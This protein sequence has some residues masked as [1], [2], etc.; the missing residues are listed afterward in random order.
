MDTYRNGLIFATLALICL[1]ANAQ[2]FMECADIEDDA[3]RLSCYD[4]AAA[5]I[6][7]SLEKPQTG[8][9]EQRQEQ[10]NAEVA[11]IVFGEE[12]APEIIEEVPE[13]ITFI[14]KDV[15]FTERRDTI[16]VAEDGRLFKKIADTRV[17]I[18]PGE[19]VSIE[20]GFFGAIFLVTEK[21]VRIKVKER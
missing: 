16:F 3:S 20:D 18:K 12:Q 14:I 5:A 1:E 13:Q 21:G 7:A 2:S 6:K 10:R 17:T 9:S 11:A 8:S 19:R 15:L 4:N